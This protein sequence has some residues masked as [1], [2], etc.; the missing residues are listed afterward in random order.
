VCSPDKAFRATRVLNSAVNFLLFLDIKGLL[1]LLYVHLSYWSSFPNPLLGNYIYIKENSI[2]KRSL[3][4]FKF[5]LLTSTLSKRLVI[6]GLTSALLVG[7]VARVGSS[8]R[9]ARSP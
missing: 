9:T 7:S 1:R 5:S 6:F 4:E 3:R 2:K 8:F